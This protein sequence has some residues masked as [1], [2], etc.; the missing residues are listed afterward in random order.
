MPKGLIRAIGAVLTA[1]ALYSLLGFLIVPGIGLRIINQQLA[2]Y[3]TTPARLD[4]LEFNPFSLELT[5]WG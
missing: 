2:H 1:L 5:L 4:R 3:A